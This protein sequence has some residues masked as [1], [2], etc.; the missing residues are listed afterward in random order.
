MG[1]MKNHHDWYRDHERDLDNFVHNHVYTNVSQMV[2]EVCSAYW[3]CLCNFSL[4][5]EQVININQKVNESFMED[6]AE[7]TYFE[8]LQHFVVDDWFALKLEERGEII[9]YD[10]LGLTIW[11]R[12]TCGQAISLDY[13]VQSIYKELN[14]VP[15]EEEV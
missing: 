4:D 11:G 3:Q 5:E 15:I 6:G 14:K 9:D 7:P 2:N 1:T 8:A 10:F 12:A 13:V